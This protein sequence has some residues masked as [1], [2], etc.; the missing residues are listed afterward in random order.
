MSDCLLL[1]EIQHFGKGSNKK[2]IIY[3][4]LGILRFFWEDEKRLNIPF[5][6]NYYIDNFK[7]LVDYDEKNN[8]ELVDTLDILLKCDLSIPR[9]AE[10]FFIHENT[11]R[12]RLKRIEK[13]T[14]RNLKKPYD[15]FALMLGLQIHHF[16]K[17]KS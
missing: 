3:N 1:Q 2:I 12:A 10:H 13:I 14:N 7:P 9:T 16:I 11:L 8:S 15:L 17:R 6:T 4:K 5:V